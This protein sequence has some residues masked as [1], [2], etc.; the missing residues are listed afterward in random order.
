[1]GKENIGW[2][3]LASLVFVSSPT[4]AE[5]GQI[6]ISQVCAVQTGCVSG[7][8]PGFP[9]TLDG[10]AG[11][12]HVLTS[13]LVVP[14]ATNGIEFVASGSS[15]DLNGFRIVRS[16]CET[17]TTNCTPLAGTGSGVSASIG[18]TGISVRNGSVVGMAASGVQ[19]RQSSLVEDVR[20]RWNANRGVS[21][22]AGSTLNS[23]VA[24]QNGQSGIVVFESTV[25]SVATARN[26]DWGLDG[27]SST[28]FGST[29]FQNGTVGFRLGASFGAYLR[30]SS[31]Y[32]N[33]QAS[34]S[35]SNFG[36][37]LNVLTVHFCASGANG[38][39]GFTNFDG[40]VIAHSASFAN[41][42]EGIRVLDTLVQG[43]TSRDSGG[44]GLLMDQGV[45]PASSSYR[46]NTI[47][48]AGGVTVS[49]GTSTGANSCNGLNF[50]P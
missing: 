11:A 40:G 7:D 16:G 20:V 27:V 6:E 32:A 28:V 24:Y 19:L 29:A 5:D 41:Q 8:A 43:S 44:D 21:V 39:R 17:A 22:S 49:G 35:S 46:G 50:C 48:N 47:T 14:L 3:L 23:V 38:G 31:A 15:L 34:P 26:A 18:V 45:V 33:G 2:I 37:G 36:I 12:S 13:D 4:W 30:A 25:R 1:M 9:V 10:S 42:F